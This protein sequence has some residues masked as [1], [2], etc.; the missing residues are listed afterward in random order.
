M[1]PETVAP[2]R[3][4][5]HRQAQAVDRS[6]DPVTK[7]EKPWRRVPIDGGAQEVHGVTPRPGMRLEQGGRRGHWLPL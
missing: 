6:F 5:R 4:F 2:A 7:P 1:V 3:D